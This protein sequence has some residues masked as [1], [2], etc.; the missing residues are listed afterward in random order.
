MLEAKNLSLQQKSAYKLKVQTFELRF[1]VLESGDTVDG[2]NFKQPPGMLKKACKYSDV[3]Y[4]YQVVQDFFHQQYLIKCRVLIGNFQVS[5]L[6]FPSLMV[7]LRYLIDA[8]QN[9]VAVPVPWAQMLRLQL[10][11]LLIKLPVLGGSNHTKYTNV[12]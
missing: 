3:I 4:L 5:N 11:D 10:L 6:V 9:T 2:R 8:T 7:F 12:W 1:N